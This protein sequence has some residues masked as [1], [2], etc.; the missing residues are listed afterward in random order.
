MAHATAGLVAD[1]LTRLQELDLAMMG[2]QS[3]SVSCDTIPAG[4]TMHKR[5]SIDRSSS[6][7][8]TAGTF[9]SSTAHAAP[10]GTLP[11]AMRASSTGSKVSRGHCAHVVCSPL[12]YGPLGGR[13]TSSHEP[14]VFVRFVQRTFDVS[15]EEEDTPTKRAKVCSYQFRAA[16]PRTFELQDSSRNK[17]VGIE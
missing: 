17:P 15:A 11:Q 4:T 9:I 7:C 3:S 16:T 13:Q 2:P 6:V 5:H 10:I 12:P 1:K 14:I 8:S